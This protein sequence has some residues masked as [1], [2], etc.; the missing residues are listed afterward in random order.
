M[1]KQGPGTK[2]V[3]RGLARAFPDIAA[4]RAREEQE[5]RERDHFSQRTQTSSR[6]DG[7]EDRQGGGSTR[8]RAGLREDLRSHDKGQHGR[9]G[10]EIHSR[11]GEEEFEYGGDGR[12]ESVG[13]GPSRRT[14]CEDRGCGGRSGGHGRVE[15]VRRET[16]LSRHTDSR[17]QGYQSQSGGH[18]RAESIRRE[19]SIR[20]HSK[21][22]HGQDSRDK[23][24]SRAVFIPQAHSHSKASSAPSSSSA[25]RSTKS[26]G[27][28]NL[29]VVEEIPIRRG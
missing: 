9:R 19:P 14:G 16:Q 7:G 15:S 28:N 12:R 29:S 17:D 1:P 25:R 23:G 13:R 6:R 10:S 18:S 5:E 2:L 3:L 22:P 11:R 4:Q 21:Y 27:G 8:S 26:R 20:S 24:Q